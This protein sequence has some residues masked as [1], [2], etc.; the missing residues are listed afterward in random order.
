MP[1]KLAQPQSSFILGIT[2]GIGCGKTTVTNQ[3]AALGIDIIDADIV[4]REVVT[5]PSSALDSI[6]AHFGPRV[7]QADGTLNR[8]ALREIIFADD[9]SKLWLNDLLH[10][11]IRHSIEQQLQASQ[12]PYVIL[13]APLL[14]EN[15]LEKLVDQTLVI[16]ISEAEQIARTCLRD[17]V[18][19]VQVKAIIA[20]Q[21][22]RQQRLDRADHI[23]CNDGDKDRLEAKIKTLHQQF[24]TFAQAK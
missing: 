11:I 5:P 24:L 14:F 10:P 8:A 13:V 7:I 4:A 17:Q 21:I 16:D 20:S 9:S 1:H 2:G 12:S 22:P 6:A 15:Q 18:D 3:F 23:L 19:A